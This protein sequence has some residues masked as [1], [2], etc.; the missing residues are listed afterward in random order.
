MAIAILIV[1]TGTG[2]E[3]ASNRAES[4]VFSL[5][6]AAEWTVRGASAS[7]AGMAGA[8]EIT[9]IRDW[10]EIEFGGSILANSGHTELSADVVFKKPFRLSESTEFMIGVGPSIMKTTSGPDRGIERAAELD[11]DFMFWPQEKIGWYVQPT[12]SVVPKSGNQSVGVSVG[13]LLRIL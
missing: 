5:G 1:A 6:P 8:L 12:W 9:P 3:E 11:L 7:K 4:P 2:A 10:L 13:L